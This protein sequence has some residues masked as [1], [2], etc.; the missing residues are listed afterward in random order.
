MLRLA[1]SAL[2][3]FPLVAAGQGDPVTKPLPTRTAATRPPAPANVTASITG[4][5]QVT[6]SWDAVAGASA[7]DIG[8]HVPPDGWRRLT[9]VTGAT[10]YVDG[11]R[12]LS[13]PHM[14]Q[15]VA[16]VGYLAS[17]PARSDTVIATQQAA[18][19]SSAVE[20]VPEPVRTAADAGCSTPYPDAWSCKSAN[21]EWTGRHAGV[22]TMIASCPSGF[23]VV[24]GG[25][26]GHFEGATVI[27]SNPVY[28]EGW[29]IRINGIPTDN[30][31]QPNR[32]WA[33]AYCR[34]EP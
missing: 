21:Y 23:R 29:Q 5:G 31:T 4:P 33:V 26:E 34:R 2:V 11:G 28:P 6:I 32:I 20:P 9:R 7:Y 16:I 10:S 30:P 13:K 3:I 12:D 15:V 24:S 25:H 8:L 27:A 14:Y 1:V 22:Y 19:D 17:L 18:V